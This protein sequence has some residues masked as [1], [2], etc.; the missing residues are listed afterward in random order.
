VDEDEFVRM[1]MARDATR[2]AEADPA[3]G[4]GQHARRRVPP[5]EDDGQTFLK[6][7]LNQLLAEE[8]SDAEAEQ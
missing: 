2:H 1:R 7:P 5:A 4:A 6:I 3:V 8:G